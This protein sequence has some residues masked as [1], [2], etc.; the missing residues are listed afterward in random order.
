MLVFTADTY[1]G[2]EGLWVRKQKYC[3][4]LYSDWREYRVACSNAK[5]YTVMLV[6]HYYD[7]PTT[8]YSL[9]L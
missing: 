5:T 8:V 6:L 2:T 3:I 1:Q 9:K 4:D 7:V